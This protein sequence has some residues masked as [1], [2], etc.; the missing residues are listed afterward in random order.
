M[1]R[2]VVLALPLLFDTSASSFLR[3][4][5]FQHV[6]HDAANVAG[7]IRR[8]PGDDYES[9][10]KRANE[11]SELSDK[12]QAASRDVQ[13]ARRDYAYWKNYY[14]T[15]EANLREQ[16]AIRK[17]QIANKP[18][19]NQTDVELRREDHYE[20]VMCYKIM[21]AFVFNQD[22]QQKRLHVLEVCMGRESLTFFQSRPLPSRT[23]APKR[24]PLVNGSLVW[25]THF[26]EKMEQLDNKVHALEKEVVRIGGPEEMKQMLHDLEQEEAAIKSQ[27]AADKQRWSQECDEIADEEQALGEEHVDNYH[28]HQAIKVAAAQKAKDKF[29]PVVNK[30]YRVNEDNIRDFVQQECG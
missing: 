18:S 8:S 10:V 6:S 5:E 2:S 21:D 15:K 17:R 19:P 9:A 4:I 27:L 28:D 3:Q 13:E 20:A 25:L 16:I 29:C 23:D 22:D 1:K 14:A 30:N 7:T 12:I 24:L 26:S 11:V